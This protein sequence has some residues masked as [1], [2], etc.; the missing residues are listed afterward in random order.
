MPKTVTL[1]RLTLRS[2]GAIELEWLL[3]YVEA[4]GTPVTDMRGSVL[5]DTQR[6]IVDPDG[7]YAANIDDVCNALAEGGFVTTKAQ[8]DRMKQMVGGVDSLA[9]TDTE[10]EAKRQASITRKAANEALAKRSR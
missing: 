2:D 10:T 3:Q 7:D 9:R 4:D 5:K 1:D 8:R 6:R